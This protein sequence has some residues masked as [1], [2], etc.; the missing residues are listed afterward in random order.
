MRD[1][2]E[3]EE[4]TRRGE[5]RRRRAEEEM[6]TRHRVHPLEKIVHV[7]LGCARLGVARVYQDG[8]DFGLEVEFV[9]D[10]LARSAGFKAKGL[11]M[12]GA[13]FRRG[14]TREAREE[15][16]QDSDGKTKEEGVERENDETHSGSCCDYCTAEM[17]LSP[18]PLSSLSPP[19]TT[20][21]SAHHVR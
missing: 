10:D 11:R 13:G 1:R 4:R 7:H 19:L 6:K 15:G 12:R 2:E 20:P 8:L 16:E 3:K 5:E 18:L 9:G 17:R 14:K 21:C